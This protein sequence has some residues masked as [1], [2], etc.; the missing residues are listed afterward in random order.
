MSERKNDTLYNISVW[1]RTHTGS[2]FTEWKYDFTSSVLD[3]S[4][5]KKH[6]VDWGQ[7]RIKIS[8]YTAGLDNFSVTLF[9]NNFD[10][11][12]SLDEFLGVV[13]SCKYGFG[14]LGLEIIEGD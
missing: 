1:H 11:D 9:D 14:L 12:L 6:L 8:A 5:L 2:E 3:I 4:L 13:R 10:E 7:N